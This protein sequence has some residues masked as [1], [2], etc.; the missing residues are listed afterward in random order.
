MTSISRSAATALLRAVRSAFDT[1]RRH[2]APMPGGAGNA[3]RHAARRARTGHQLAGRLLV[4][5]AVG[6]AGAL[7][8]QA[9]A[10]IN[11]DGWA[12]LLWHNPGN[13][14]VGAWLLNGS[15]SVAGFPLL[16]GTCGP[17]GGCA[18]SWRPV[19]PIGLSRVLWHNAT[20]GDLLEWMLDGSTVTGVQTLDAKCA[21]NTGCSQSWTAVGSGEF[22]LRQGY[23]DADILWHNAATGD[24]G[25]WIVT[26]TAVEPLPI[27]LRCGAADGC[28]ASSK[29]VGVSRHDSMKILWHNSVT[30]ELRYWNMVDTPSV[31]PVP[32]GSPRFSYYTTVGS[33]SA[34]LSWTCPASN[35]CASQWR[36]IGVDDVNGDGRDDVIWFNPQSGVIS[37]WLMNGTT[38]MSSRELTT[39]CSRPSGC[40]TA[41]NPI[42]L[43][44]GAGRP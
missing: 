3:A 31:H 7:H 9:H 18:T 33:V 17:A 12:D 14:Q 20:T 42:G 19:G 30:G 40:S 41:W 38:V 5:A 24:L 26:G 21:A 27:N 22:H 2:R 10:D 13:G 23:H 6:A 8:G 44:T 29:V 43:I 15:S 11:N 37:A 36:V 28:S 34:P 39:T 16:S 4:S 35:G 25:V 32:P 1:I